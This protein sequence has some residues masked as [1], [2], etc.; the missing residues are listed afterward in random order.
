[1]MN[2]NYTGNDRRRY[3][4]IKLNLTVNYRVDGP[5][6]VR[7][8]FGDQEIEATTLNLCEGGMAILTGYDIPVTSSLSL[9]FFLFKIDNEGQV[10]FYDPVEINAGV[11]SNIAC[12]NDQYRLGLCFTRTEISQNSRM[13]DFVKLAS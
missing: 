12:G 6:Y 10:R 5:W 3:Q 2:Y 1:M 8:K 4:R 9:K 7:V 13:S 11:R